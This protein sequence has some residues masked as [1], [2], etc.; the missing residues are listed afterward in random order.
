MSNNMALKFPAQSGKEKKLWQLEID[1]LF[2]VWFELLF[3]HGF[4]IVSKGFA[5]FL[6]DFDVG[7]CVF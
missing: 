1:R 3:S 4:S 5:D 7:A 2:C 6:S